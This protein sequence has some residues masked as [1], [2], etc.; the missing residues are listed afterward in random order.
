MIKIHNECTFLRPDG[1]AKMENM[2]KATFVME[3]CIKG[4]HGWANFPAAIFYT[5]ED[6]KSTRLNSS[7]SQQSRMPS[8]A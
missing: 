2:Y 3:S 7:H 6:R 4:K 5:E 8:S 1:I